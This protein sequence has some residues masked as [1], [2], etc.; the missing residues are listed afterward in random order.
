MSIG[1]RRAGTTPTS[2]KLMGFTTQS[3]TIEKKGYGKVVQ[4]FYSKVA[5]DRVT[6]K[7]TRGR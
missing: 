6:V 3:L 4:K 7:L 1:G 2:I 5:S